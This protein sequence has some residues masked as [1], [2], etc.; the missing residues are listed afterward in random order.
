MGYFLTSISLEYQEAYPQQ[1]HATL[2]WILRP[3]P[4]F[5]SEHLQNLVQRIIIIWRFVVYK[6]GSYRMGGLD[7]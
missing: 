5:V 1:L 3:Q 6:D 4:G 2:T 7:G